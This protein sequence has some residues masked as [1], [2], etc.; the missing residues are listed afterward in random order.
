MSKSRAP[1]RRIVFTEA[2]VDRFVVLWTKAV[3]VK[4]VA[5]H[6]D[7]TETT[8]SAMANR[9]RKKGLELKKFTRKS[10]LD[11]VRL[12]ELIKAS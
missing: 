7:I 6:M 1:S 11:I 12:N 3:S 4:E 8:A 2:E 9:L 10:S 5:E